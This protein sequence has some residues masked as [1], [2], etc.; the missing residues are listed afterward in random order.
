MEI[1][2]DWGYWGL[3][4]GSFLASTVMPFSSDALLIAAILA[5]GDVALVVI[6]ATIGNSLGGLTSYY[7]GYLGRWEWIE[8]FLHISREKL[9]KQAALIQKYGSLIAFMSWVPILG[10]VVTVAL[11]FYRVNFIRCSIYMFIGRALRFIGWALIFAR[12][13]GAE[14]LM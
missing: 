1:L 3:F 10:D 9:E 14:A 7:I 5:G 11:G 8:R 2:G 13:G 6:Y 4:L 12:V